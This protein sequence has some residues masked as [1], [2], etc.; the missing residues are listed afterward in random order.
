MLSSE[1]LIILP[2]VIVAAWAILLLVADLFL[3]ASRK[4]ITPLL[5]ALGLAIALGATFA[6][7]STVGQGG[8]AFYG[9]VVLDGFAVFSNVLILTS[10]LLGV[11]LA[12]DYL[13]RMDIDRSEYYVLLLISTAGMMLM[14]QAYDLIVVFL[15][16]ELLSIP[17]YVMAG[18]ARPRSESEEAALKYFLLGAFSAA[19]FLYG[20]ALIYGAT[21]HTDLTGIVTAVQA[22]GPNVNIQ[23]LIAGAA[24]LLVALG[25]KISAVPFHM[26]TPDVYQGAPT[27]VT[28]WMAV[29]VKVAGF[30]ALLRAFMIVF[31]S[32]AAGL[33]AIIGGLAALTM[34]IGNLLAIVQ[35]SIKRLLAY[36][37]IA[38]VGYL[39]LAF[40]PYGSGTVVAAG[41]G[42]AVSDAVTASLF[43]LVGYGLASFAA[44]GVVIA[45]EQKEGRGLDLQDYAG[46]GRKY[47]WLGLAM[48]AAMF[49]FTGIPLT[50]GFWGKF[51]IFQAALKGGAVG[52][53]LLGLLTSLI[54]AYY[55]LRVLVIMYMQ[56]GEAPIHQEKWLSFVAIASAAA[57]VLLAAFPYPLFNLAAHAV[58]RLP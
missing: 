20:T 2:L 28:A 49:S 16:L 15:A 10:G 18:F 30:A 23:L 54:S 31:P 40:V 56:P 51:Y 42:A 32:H 8:P 5:A 43:Y 14:V 50:L 58:F 45:A 52:L 35:T 4:G 55:Y 29:S 33:T 13:R 6:L 1:F 37:S 57:V 41:A 46:L 25:F 34:I 9:M 53:A 19:F 12:Y 11:A 38:H 44:W 22:G 17:L 24:L 27:P 26:W 39:L 21:A 47:P 3:P 48:M 36:S 7:G